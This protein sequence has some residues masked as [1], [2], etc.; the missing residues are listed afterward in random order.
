MTRNKKQTK[1][2]NQNWKLI[3]T[4]EVTQLFSA[5]PNRQFNYKQVASLLE[6][7]NTQNRKLVYS[8]LQEMSQQGVIKEISTVK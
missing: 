6:V 5:N 1:G 7:N 3:L 2:K 8:I 4:S